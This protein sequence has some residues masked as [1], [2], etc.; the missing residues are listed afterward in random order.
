MSACQL[1]NRNKSVCVSEYI[2]IYI[3]YIY[4]C[5]IPKCDVSQPLH[6]INHLGGTSHQKWHL[7][8]EVSFRLLQCLHRCSS[9][10]PLG[11][12]E[13][14]RSGGAM[15]HDRP[16]GGEHVW[17]FVNGVKPRNRNA[18]SSMWFCSRGLVHKILSQTGPNC[19]FSC[20]FWGYATLINYLGCF[21]TPKKDA[22]RMVVQW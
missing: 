22:T 17:T 20:F 8:P 19:F 14:L 18:V 21:G 16:L 4:I 7:P 2:Y 11:F 10:L 1:G 15:C 6:L 3:I 13:F 5:G 9:S 12:G